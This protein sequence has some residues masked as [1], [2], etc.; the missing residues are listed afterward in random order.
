MA[1]EGAN[2]HLTCAIWKPQRPTV[3]LILIP[4]VPLATLGSPGEA[5]G[6]NVH[7]HLRPDKAC[8]CNITQ[9]KRPDGSC[10]ELPC[11][12]LGAIAGGVDK[13]NDLQ[14]L[15]VDPLS[16][17]RDFYDPIRLPRRGHRAC[18][19]RQ[20]RAVCFSVCGNRGQASDHDGRGDQVV[21][22]FH[23]GLPQKMNGIWLACRSPAQNQFSH[24]QNTTRAGTRT[25]VRPKTGHT[26]RS[27]G[28]CPLTYQAESQMDLVFS[29]S[30]WIVGPGAE[31]HMAQS[32]PS[33][34]SGI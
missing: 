10:V 30:D 34:M 3:G 23:D 25:G 21:H 31:R 17:G 20:R 1:I 11:E 18:R 8:G 15:D 32:L 26:N 13:L 9:V 33:A 7:H 12:R 16:L 14:S 28:N 22:G 5:A 19:G 24:R 29:L 27:R 2:G 6:C 4:S